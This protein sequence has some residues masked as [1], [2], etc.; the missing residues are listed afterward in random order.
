MSPAAREALRDHLLRRS[1]RSPS[2]RRR[3]ARHR[4]VPV[5]PGRRGCG[6]TASRTRAAS[7]ERE[8]VDLAHAPG[9]VM[10]AARRR[11]LSRRARRSAR[12][13]GPSRTP[14]RA[15]ARRRRVA[16]RSAASSRTRRSASPQRVDVAGRDEQRLAVGP[17]DVRVALDR[18]TR[19][20]AC[21]RPSPRAARRRTTRRAATARRTRSRRACAASSSASEMLP[22]H[23]TFATLRLR[24]S[25]VCGP[26]AATHRTA[27]RSSRDHASSSDAKSLA[28][29][30]PA[31]EEHRRH[32]RRR[33]RRVREAVDLD[34][35]P[36]HVVL[37]APVR[38]GGVARGLRDDDAG[39]EP[40]HQRR[41][42][43]A[44]STGAAAHPTRGTSRPS[45]R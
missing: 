37:A 8:L 14:R 2:W 16:S 7:L 43:R 19:R 4:R 18:R 21:P 25:F 9:A 44:G 39:R 12:R 27:S 5:R 10:L 42:S 36:E 23:S 45:D 13:A 22:S 15:P 33:R 3:R 40:R 32:R 31:D 38:P 11:P 34:A 24:S 28:G 26:V 29:L 17:G 30:V 35:V 20:P 41:A 1:R 6:A